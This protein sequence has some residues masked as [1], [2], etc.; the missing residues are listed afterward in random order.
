MY[1]INNKLHIFFSVRHSGGVTRFNFEYFRSYKVGILNLD[2]NIL[3]GG[4]GKVIKK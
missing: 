4:M 1:L 3:D 2:Q